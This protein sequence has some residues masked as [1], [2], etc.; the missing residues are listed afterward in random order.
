MIRTPLSAILAACALVVSGCGSDGS[1]TSTVS[2]SGSS[3]STTTA[4]VAGDAS[5]HH[6]MDED[7][8]ASA[9]PDRPTNAEFNG[10]ER[11]LLAEQLLQARAVALSL[12][13]YADALAAGYEPTTPYAPGTGSHLGKDADTQP[14][15]ASL[16]IS[17]PQSFLYAGT[18]PTSPVVG[19]MYVQLGGD[20]PPDGFSGPLDTWVNP[21][22]GQCLTPGEMDPMFP[23]GGEI[24]KEKCDAAGGNYVD[25]TAY[26][27]HVWVVPG[28]EA[29][30]GVFAEY[31]TDIVCADGTT[32]TSETE[33]CEPPAGGL[34]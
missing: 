24:P 28:W 20:S 19:L 27:Q 32:D 26:I 22:V 33:G 12:P 34:G 16:D 14:P 13:T 29:P 6:T 7:D 30:G 11:R 1:A 10:E 23:T 2:E 18:E 8:A 21:V 25:I 31:N 17:K 4:Q 3:E 9:P 5:D 15:G